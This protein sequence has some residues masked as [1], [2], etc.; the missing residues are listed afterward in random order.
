MRRHAPILAGLAAVVAL[1][2]C[3]EEK[4]PLATNEQL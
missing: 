4:K 3:H 1:S 2:G